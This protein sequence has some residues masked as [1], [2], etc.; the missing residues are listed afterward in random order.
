MA[1]EINFVIY[2][3][4]IFSIREAIMNKQKPA[5]IAKEAIKPLFFPGHKLL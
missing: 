4:D 2:F 1:P 3:Q 5:T